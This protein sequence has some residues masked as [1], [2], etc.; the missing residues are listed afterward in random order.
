MH[1]RET[2]RRMDV[3][4]PQDGFRRPY[5]ADEVRWPSVSLPIPE[6][7][8][9]Y[10]HLQ[11]G[12]FTSPN[13]RSSPPFPLPEP[14]SSLESTQTAARA[15]HTY[16]WLAMVPTAPRFDDP[17]LDGLSLKS[18]RAL[19]IV[20]ISQT[21]YRLNDNSIT[22]WAEVEDR[23]LYVARA[24]SKQSRKFLGAVKPPSPFTFGYKKSYNTAEDTLKA[25]QQ[26][27]LAFRV[28]MGYCGFCMA[29]H[30]PDINDHSDFR[31]CWEMDLAKQKVPHNV[32][33]LVR[34]SELN[35]FNAN[36]PR[37]G[38]V[39]YH[40]C[41]ML[42][43]M[44]ALVKWDVPVWIY[45]GAVNGPLF[46]YES[47]FFKFSPPYQDEID[48][49]LSMLRRPSRSSSS[50]PIFEGSGQQPGELG[51]VY[52]ARR[53]RE[54][55]EFVMKAD[56]RERA[57]FYSKAAAQ[58]THPLP[59]FPGPRVWTWQRKD[60]YDLK[61]STT[62]SDAIQ[63][64]RDF[65]DSHRRYDPQRDEWDLFYE[66]IPSTTPHFSGILKLKSPSYQLSPS[67]N[68]PNFE[69]LESSLD[70][71]NDELPPLPDDPQPPDLPIPSDLPAFD[72]SGEKAWKQPKIM[73]R[74]NMA[75]DIGQPHS[76]DSAITAPEWSHSQGLEDHL[77][78]RFG[79][80]PLHCQSSCSNEALSWDKICK[81]LGDTVHAVENRNCSCIRAFVTY[82]IQNHA[83]I[84][85]LQ[86]YRAFD[87]SADAENPFQNESSLG[88]RLLHHNGQR[89]YNI[90]PKQD[91]E[92]QPSWKLVVADPAAVLQCFRASLG[93][94]I[95]NAARLLLHNGIPFNTFKYFSQTSSD[96]HKRV[97]YAIH[98]LTHRP[99]R[100][101][102]DTDDYS[103]YE[104]IR[105][106]ILTRPYKRAAL[107]E[108][109]IVWRLALHALQYS[110][111]SEL[112]ITQGPSE[113]AFSRGRVLELSDEKL[114]DDILRDNE[115]DLICGVYELETGASFSPGIWKKVL[116]IL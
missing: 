75:P 71:H 98:K 33:D 87:L 66:A 83:D 40:D 53:A 62:R 100:H 44:S 96:S 25:A 73:P 41:K 67:A 24:L 35:L 34:N 42:S 88:A 4:R 8:F 38:V 11:H 80:S 61:S 82:M 84:G 85:A 17:L 109:G 9:V 7:D 69:M 2:E 79:F 14:F 23:L 95:R 37:A 78:G 104:E 58:M 63:I 13:C 21:T 3:A 12:I 51:L 77:Y 64:W 54:I 18:P 105:D 59:S 76:F 6:S 36:Y 27:H 19:E 50:P 101:I 111:D 99:L 116:I 45:W 103:R 102:P 112:F 108:G 46:G 39:V 29:T 26:S 60:G 94:S 92:R 43:F 90:N 115:K 106:R 32:I 30:T 48:R 114:Y 22:S 1:C 20:T 16:P 15:N 55:A 93:G 70:M 81:T 52:I 89:L 113:D 5:S 56:E 65:E 57:V 72:Q 28:L 91:L 68:E 74:S 49:G 110:T 107:L 47:K 97:T 10:C 86:R 31:R